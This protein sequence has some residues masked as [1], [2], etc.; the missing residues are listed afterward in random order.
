MMRLLGV[1]LGEDRILG[2]KFPQERQR[3]EFSKRGARET[4]EQHEYRL[5]AHR[6]LEPDDAEL[7]AKAKDMNPNGFWECPF[8][9]RG[10]RFQVSMEK[11]LR[12]LE[13]ETERQTICKIVSQGL[14][15]SDPRYISKIIF[16]VR[17]PRAVAKSQERLRR[18]MKF[19]TEDGVEHDLYE[20]ATVHSPK[21]FIDVTVA[22]M[23]WIEEHF[24]IPVLLVRYDDLIGDAARTLARVGAFLREGDAAAWMRAAQEIDPNLRRSYPQEQKSNLWGDA[25]AVYRM[26]EGLDFEGARKFRNDTRTMTSREER[27]W[28]CLR[29]EQ[30]VVEVHCLRCKKNHEGFRTNLREYADERHI[31]WRE[32]PCAFEV[33]HDLDNSLIDI[34]SSIDDNFWV[35]AREQRTG[36]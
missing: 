27:S 24:E 25:E 6:L 11:K 1:A 30:E 4:Y 35:C 28:T 16:M 2:E 22:A 26:L 29:C 8:T 34:E 3:G 21:M 20:G 19:R 18:E 9:V 31:P 12:D 10:V 5:Y 33:A 15:Q 17:H 14:A 23:R 7:L 36:S 13:A 32:R